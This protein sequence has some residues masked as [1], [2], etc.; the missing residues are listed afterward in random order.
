LT[1]STLM[2]D[3]GSLSLAHDQGEGQATVWV[4]VGSGLAVILLTVGSAVF[5][6]AC[7]R[8]LLGPAVDEIGSNSNTAMPREDMPSSTEDVSLMSEEN[9][10]SSHSQDL[11]QVD[12]NDDRQE[13]LS[14][15]GLLL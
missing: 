9:A 14:T 7:S 5:L 2:L 8:R 1:E 3:L 13:G 10:I 11:S 15:I 4:G 6:F 12:F